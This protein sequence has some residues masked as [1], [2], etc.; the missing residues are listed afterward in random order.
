M[1]LIKTIAAA[2]LLVL[3]TTVMGQGQGN[4]Q[5]RSSSERAKTETESIV[6][7][8]ALT[9][10][11][12]AKVLEINLKYAAKDSIRFAEMRASGANMD[13]DAMMKSMTEQRAAQTVEVKAVMTDDQKAKYDAYIKDR[14]AQRAARMGGQG[15][16]QGGQGGGQGGGFGGQ[17]P[18]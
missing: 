6:K 7:A 10:E 5:M 14:D 16:G 11:Q 1:K 18:N 9:P 8:V 3:S 15:G 13:R 17:R 4:R 2:A 12:A